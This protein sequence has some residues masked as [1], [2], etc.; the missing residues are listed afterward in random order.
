MRSR[1]LSRPTLVVAILLLFGAAFGPGCAQPD[2]T[3]PTSALPDSALPTPTLPASTLPAPTVTPSG[4]DDT[5]VIQAAVDACGTRGGTVTF[6]PGTYRVT[7][8]VKLPPGNTAPLT[9][10][11]HGAKIVLDGAIG[12]LELDDTADHQDF[13]YFAIRGFEVDAARRRNISG[14]AF[15]GATNAFGNYFTK[16]GNVE[17]VTI[18]DVW[19]HGAPAV[20]GGTCAAIGLGSKQGGVREATTNNVRHITIDDVRIEGGDSGILVMTELSVAGVP[21]IDQWPADVNQVCDDIAISNVHFDSGKAPPFGTRQHHVG[22]QVNGWGKGGTLTVRDCSLKGSADDLLEIDNMRVAE[23]TDVY[24]KESFDIAFTVRGFGYTLD[25]KPPAEGT[26]R[27]TYTDC[28]YEMGTR[29]AETPTGFGYAWQEINP[30]DHPTYRVT[31]VDCQDIL[32]DGTSRPYT[33]PSPV[34]E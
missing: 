25:A 6:A 26:M 7:S 23:V 24:A 3:Q 17:H 29:G 28:T 33:G 1:R 30:A 2:S 21:P 13:R 27:V 14:C 20:P 11:G 12:F 34:P 8:S 22:I 31:Y 16:R 10:S 18:E 15:I 4:G 9:L 32:P 19:V 5:V